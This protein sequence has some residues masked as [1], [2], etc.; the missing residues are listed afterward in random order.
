[1]N[2]PFGFAA[3]GGDD[4]PDDTSRDKSRGAGGDGGTGDSGNPG[5]SGNP[6]MGGTFG[7]HMPGG[8]FSGGVGDLGNLLNQFGQMLGSMGSAINNPEPGPVNYSL[9]ENMALAQV[10]KST[11]VSEAQDKAVVEAIRLAELW[12][13]DTT[14]FPSAAHRTE[15]WTPRTWVERS[16]PAW[17]EVCT[18]LAEQINDATQESMPE[19]AKQMAGPLLGMLNAMGGMGFGMQLGHGLG[20]LAPAILFASEIGFP[21]APAGTAA[22]LPKA[23]SEFAKELEL[24]AQEVMVFL[25]ARE[26]AHVR[27]YEHAP[28]LH[29]RMV[30]AIEEYARGIRIDNSSMDELAG[31]LGGEF[32]MSMLSDPQK[33]QE[34]LGSGDIGPKITN[35]NEGARELLETLLALVEGWVD[36]VVA[37]AIG[38]RLPG[39]A[40]L[41]ETWIRRRATG[42]AAEKTFA[43]MVGL[44][45]RPRMAPEA[46]T[47]W[48]RITDTVGISDRDRLWSH[49]DL[50]PDAT[51]I[52]NPAA[53]IDRILSADEDAA[54]AATGSGDVDPFDEIEEF[55]RQQAD[56]GTNGSAGSEDGDTGDTGPDGSAP[57]GSAGGV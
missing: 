52:T 12:L 1:M 54:R 2:Q 43:T 13:D 19:E 46:A 53:V 14:E 9:A 17:K 47:M 3:S 23:I 48:Q 40:A 26:A 36:V 39:A 4:E 8:G 37:A 25:A 28:W 31:K 33:M 56:R 45:L 5:G 24:P 57:G 34:L 11:H 35:V 32:D 15:A 22:L 44:E 20:T 21:F 29:A 27:L 41:R 49:P 38:D 7:F 10:G 30:G 51:D 50:L 6:G 18:P 42:G 55:L 16:L